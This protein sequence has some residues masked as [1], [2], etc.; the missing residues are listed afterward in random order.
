MSLISSLKT[1]VSSDAFTLDNMFN[2]AVSKVRVPSNTVSIGGFIFDRIDSINGANPWNITESPTSS[3]S[4]VIEHVVA[5]LKT[6]NIKGWIYKYVSK[7]DN[8]FDQLTRSVSNRLSQVNA[9]LPQYAGP[10][11]SV[12]N[13]AVQ[14]TDQ[15][16]SFIDS[17]LGAT[18]GVYNEILGYMGNGQVERHVKNKEALLAMQGT[19]VKLSIFGV[20]FSENFIMKDVNIN[21]DGTNAFDAFQ[22]DVNLVEYAQVAEIQTTIIENNNRLDANLAKQTK[23]TVNT[24]S[25]GKQKDVSVLKASGFFG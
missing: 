22:V 6:F 15:V 14:K 12:F 4:R 19:L 21:V 11:Q 7:D 9:Y 18:K 25:G 23:D 10:V 13:E 2:K 3:G 8:T 5:G 17:T 24:Q 20:K 1:N 16:K